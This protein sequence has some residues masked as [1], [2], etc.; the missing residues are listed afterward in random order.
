M[1]LRLLS[2]VNLIFIL[3]H[4]IDMYGRKTCFI[5]MVKANWPWLVVECL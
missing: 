5:V 4:L 2:R 3:S 1:L